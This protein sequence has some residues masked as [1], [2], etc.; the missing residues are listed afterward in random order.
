MNSP[1]VVPS[2]PCLPDLSLNCVIRLASPNPV[3]HESNQASS[4]CSGTCDCTNRIERSGSTPAAR[5]WAA[6]RRVRSR[7][8]DGSGLTVSACR[9]TTQ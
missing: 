7:S 8:T 5:Y 9:S 1:T 2:V 6:V 3:W 4:A